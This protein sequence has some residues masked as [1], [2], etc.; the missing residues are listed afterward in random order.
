MNMRI[1]ALLLAGLSAV[2]CASR[3]RPPVSPQ[4]QLH[5]L[6]VNVNVDGK[7]RPDAR[8]DLRDGPKAGAVQ[9]TDVTGNAF[10]F[11]IPTAGFN[12]CANV[13]G[14]P[15]KCVGV[16]LDHSQHVGID[17]ESV[18]N[19]PP[20]PGPGPVEPG[21]RPYVGQLSTE[22]GGGYID[23]TGAPQL[24]IFN[25][26]GDA[27]SR[28][29]R[30][31]AGV[32][33]ELDLIKSRGYAGIR[34]WTTLG[35]DSDYWRGRGVGPFE[36]DTPNYWEG[37][38]AFL[39]L[40]R[41]KGLVVHLSQGDVRQNVIRD[42]RDFAYRMCDVA[43]EV[44]V[45]VIA[46]FE[47]ANESRDT[48]EQDENRLAQF[49]GWFVERCPSVKVRGLSAFT[50]TEDVEVINRFSKSPSTIFFVHSY[51]GG[52]W[53]DKVRHIFSFQYE[54]DPEKRLGWQGEPAGPGRLVSA[55]DNR[56][57]LDADALSLM[58]AISLV[59][60]QQWVYFSGPG[61]ISNHPN[62]ERFEHMPGFSEVPRVVSMLPADVMRYDLLIHGGE[63]S[64]GAVAPFLASGENRSDCAI[65]RPDGRFACVIYGPHPDDVKPNPRKRLEIQKETRLGSKG[66][67][68]YGRM[69]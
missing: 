41:D 56:D 31:P 51:R 1:V 10:F 4:P 15:E 43:T 28:F 2:S 23:A 21:S 13:D 44:G 5:T 22:P 20:D 32:A 16:T 49:V 14:I 36:A 40:V 39:T 42:R 69:H 60:R 24:L 52:R 67:V 57:E 12:V 11:A 64:W 27:L 62:G 66:R 48:G 26:F 68:V 8:V 6:G 37:V 53:W 18:Q 29:F 34:F 38:K 55:I 19:P 54:G 63:A 65:Y 35:G 9:T 61:V 17:L 30:D 46:A 33:A 58:A 25:H 3:P 45:D 50:G 7:A 59:T 47:G